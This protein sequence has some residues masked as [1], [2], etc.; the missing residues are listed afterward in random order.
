MMNLTFR[1]ICN[2]ENLFN[3]IDNCLGPVYLQGGTE[4]RIDLRQNKEIK[5]M[6]AEACERNEI[7]KLEV[8]IS[9]SRDMPQILNY[10]LAHK[11]LP[12]N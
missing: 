1:N 10:L 8:I 7:E 12:A 4:R 5:K 9:C 6:L 3:L 11:R 2:V